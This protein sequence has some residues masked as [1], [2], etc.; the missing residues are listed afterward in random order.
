M[1]LKLSFVSRWLVTTFDLI[2]SHPNR[3]NFLMVS[4]PNRLKFKFKHY[5]L[6]AK[7]CIFSLRLLLILQR[8]S[9]Q[10]LLSQCLPWLRSEQLHLIPTSGDLRDEHNMPVRVFGS[11][12]RSVSGTTNSP[13]GRFKV[14]L[15]AK[16]CF[17]MGHPRPLSGYFRYFQESIQ[18][19]QHM[20]LKYHF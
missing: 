14:C 1:L 20:N 2:V 13:E 10:Q 4:D 7:C 6:K 12:L 19:L 11:G 8:Q 5:V 18:R 3:L 15:V 17:Q 9:H 16:F